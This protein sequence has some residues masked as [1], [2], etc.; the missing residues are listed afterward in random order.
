MERTPLADLVAVVEELATENEAAKYVLEH[1]TRDGENWRRLLGTTNRSEEMTNRV[2]P[3][4]DEAFQ[5]AQMVP[6]TAGTD[7]ALLL[8]REAILEVRFPVKPRKSGETL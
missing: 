2:K 7:H 3:L 8:L 4:F 6:S 1:Y 5:A